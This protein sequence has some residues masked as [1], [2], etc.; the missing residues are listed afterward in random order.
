MIE[1]TSG[2]SLSRSRFTLRKSAKPSPRRSVIMMWA[3][4]LR[5]RSRMSLW[6]PLIRARAMIRAA[7]PMA[8]PRMETSEMIEMKEFLRPLVR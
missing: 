3:D 6:K 5:M 7:T 8:M 2:N 1:R 4:E